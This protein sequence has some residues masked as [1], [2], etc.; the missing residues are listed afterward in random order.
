[1]SN[2]YPNEGGIRGA[3]FVKFV[4]VTMAS[5]TSKVITGF[6]TAIDLVEVEMEHPKFANIHTSPSFITKKLS[7][8]DLIK[9][10]ENTNAYLA[11]DGSS[12]SK[13]DNFDSIKFSTS[14]GYADFKAM[15]AIFKNPAKR[16]AVCIGFSVQADTGDVPGFLFIMGKALGDLEGDFKEDI[17]TYEITVEGSEVLTY[18]TT[19]AEGLTAFNAK[20]NGT[21]TLIDGSSTWTVPVVPAGSSA[22]ADEWDDLLS[23]KL[24][25]VNK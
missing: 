20:M 13:D 18:T 2:T 22:T 17:I 5:A 16:A 10:P 8:G 9:N 6:G 15:K 12:V 25:I 19:P 11:G 4:E 7:G 24:I 23:G 3:Q 1:M 14:L 21:I